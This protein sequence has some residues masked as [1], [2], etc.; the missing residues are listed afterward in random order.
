MVCRD[1]CVDVLIIT[2]FDLKYKKIKHDN[3]TK[4]LS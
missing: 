1:V 4:K 3:L 2:P